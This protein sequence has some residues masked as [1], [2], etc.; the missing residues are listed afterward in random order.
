MK[1]KQIMKTPVIT[2]SAGTCISEVA[3]EM[4]R[5]GYGFL[6]VIDHD[7]VVGVVTGKDLATRAAARGLGLDSANV[8]VIMSFPPLS[9]FGDEDL[10]SGLEL[11]RSHFIR[12]I[13]ILDRDGELSGIVSLA[14]IEAGI[15][16][17]I[18][19]ELRHVEVLNAERQ[20]ENAST[21][22]PGLYLG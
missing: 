2:I 22:I 1:L 16:N 18:V 19:D 15:A 14:D 8:T 12:R 6:P 21:L 5:S 13:L 17:Q 10:Y 11:M 3:K 9:L 20:S 7:R 4:V